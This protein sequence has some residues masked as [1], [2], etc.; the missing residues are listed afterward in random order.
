M[1]EWEEDTGPFCDGGHYED[2][3]NC[4]QCFGE[5]YSGKEVITVLQDARTKLIE[6]GCRNTKKSVI[7]RIDSTLLKMGASNG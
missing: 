3:G 6:K 5:S 1:S 2:P 7:A 4:M